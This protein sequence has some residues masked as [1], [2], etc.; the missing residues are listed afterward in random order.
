MTGGTSDIA[1]ISLPADDGALAHALNTLQRQLDEWTLLAARIEKELA[2]GASRVDERLA[3]GRAAGHP[4][5]VSPAPE[6]AAAAG[7]AGRDDALGA[8]PPPAAAEPGGEP[9]VDAS[10]GG[11]APATAEVSAGDEDGEALLANYDAEMA[12]AIRA[13]WRAA[14]GRRTW[15][16]V[17]A[18]YEQKRA[19][20]EALLRT[21]PPEMAQAIRVQRR[22][23]CGRKSVEQLIA[24]YRV[25]PRPES[26]SWWQRI[27]K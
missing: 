26:R 25:E 10:A 15:A 16:D 7:E 13:L 19:E 2:D 18:E 9:P 17:I 24:D 14:E 23:F 20:E 6:P 11:S 27:R 3:A 12:E 22:L 8:E 5:P 1:N 21:L 4:E